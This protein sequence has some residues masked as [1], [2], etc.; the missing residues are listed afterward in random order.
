M[1]RERGLI[2]KPLLLSL[3]VVVV[4]AGCTAQNVCNRTAQCLDEEA[5][6]ELEPDSTAVCIAQFDGRIEALRA[7][8]EDDCHVLADAVIALANCQAGLDCDDF[9]EADLGGKCDDQ[10][11]DLEDAQE[12]VS[13]GECTSQD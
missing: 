7:N 1:Q 9:V 11:D 5:D 2:M 13:N 6:T 3:V 8:E 10:L 12:D 4:V